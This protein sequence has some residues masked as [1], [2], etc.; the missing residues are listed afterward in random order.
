[1]LVLRRR[2]DETIDVVL[3]N[4]ESV[5]V[6]VVDIGYNWVKLGFKA[7]DSVNIVRDDAVNKNH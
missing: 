1:M 4:G 2:L 5:S 3:D 6:T 7:P